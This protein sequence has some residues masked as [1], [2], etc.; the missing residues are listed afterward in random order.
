MASATAS[1]RVMSSAA[2]SSDDGVEIGRDAI[3]C[4]T[5]SIRAAPETPGRRTHPTSTSATACRSFAARGRRSTA[6][7]TR[8]AARPPAS[9]RNSARPRRS[10]NHTGGS[11]SSACVGNERA[12]S[13]GAASGKAACWCDQ[14]GR[15]SANT[16]VASVATSPPPCVISTHQC[17]LERLALTSRT[18]RSKAPSRDRRAEIHGQRQRIARPLRMV[19]QRPQD[20]GGRA[21]A[22]RADKGPV[23]R[24]GLALPAAIAGGDLRGVVEKMRGFGQHETLPS[25]RARAKQSRGDKASVDCFVAYAP[26]N[27]AVAIMATSPT[28]MTRR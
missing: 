4:R 6:W 25:L 23:V 12:C 28:S 21:A 13:N 26:R 19:D 8:R 22:E 14:D 5:G 27:D 7:S 9:R 18:S 17:W 2:S 20:G 16:A 10:G 1:T 15:R 3:P 11:T 24:A